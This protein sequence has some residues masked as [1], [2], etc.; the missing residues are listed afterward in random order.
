MARR[1]WVQIDGK[2]IE[3]GLEYCHPDEKP[4]EWHILGDKVYAGT[5]S[6]IDGADLSTRTKHATYMKDK[7]LAMVQDFP[8]T[9][10]QMAR[11]RY[12]GKD[13]TRKQ[14]IIDAVNKHYRR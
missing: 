9:W 7:G 12:E 13:P 3:V 14:A 6:P 2:L 8:Q 5:R 11:N 1:R 10:D 4:P